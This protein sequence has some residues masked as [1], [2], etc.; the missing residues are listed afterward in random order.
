MELPNDKSSHVCGTNP[1]QNEGHVN[2]GYDLDRDTVLPRIIFPFTGLFPDSRNF[3]R[4]VCPMMSASPC[5]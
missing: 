3:A 1:L 2:I 4:N 5:S